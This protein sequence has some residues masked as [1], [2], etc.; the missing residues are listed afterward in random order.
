MENKL[1]SNEELMRASANLHR[2]EA[3]L[4]RPLPPGVIDMKDLVDHS[5]SVSEINSIVSNAER[6]YATL[7]T[8]NRVNPRSNNSTAGGFLGCLT[9]IG[10]FGFIGFAILSFLLFHFLGIYIL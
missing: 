4:N 8:S 1:W 7:S 5:L 10:V 6:L 3:T 9:V 2:I